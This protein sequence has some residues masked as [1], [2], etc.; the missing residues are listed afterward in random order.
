MFFISRGTV[1]VFVVPESHDSSKDTPEEE[2]Y[3]ISLGAGSFFGEV[4]LLEEV[5]VRMNP[6]CGVWCAVLC[7]RP[8]IECQN[9][10]LRP[11]KS[12]SFVRRSQPLLLVVTFSEARENGKRKGGNLRGV[13]SYAR[14][15]L[16]RPRTSF[17]R[18][19]G[20][21][22]DTCRDQNRHHIAHSLYRQVCCMRT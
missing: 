15:R 9:G 5:L 22:F 1:G 18:V 3:I 4:S 6:L 20:A 16:P 21:F 2:T 13:A 7:L 11:L 17:S 10:L 14:R 12:T 19:Q 8:P